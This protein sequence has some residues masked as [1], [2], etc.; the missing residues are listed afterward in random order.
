MPEP[1]QPCGLA[2]DFAMRLL[3]DPTSQVDA[4]WFFY[5]RAS[6]RLANAVWQAVV[7][8]KVDARSQMGEAVLNL[9]QEDKDRIRLAMRQSR[10]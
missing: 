7:D 10:P 2:Y 5:V 9:R 1:I 3:E 4:G 8:G 6:E